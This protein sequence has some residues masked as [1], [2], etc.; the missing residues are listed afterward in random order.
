M[1]K[2][3]KIL[4]AAAALIGL[5]VALAV[6]AVV[7]IDPTKLVNDKKEALFATVSTKLGRTL[8]TGTV[9]ASLGTALTATIPDVRLTAATPN[10]PPQLEIRQIY[11]R[12]SLLRALF[13]LGR[14]LR[15][16]QITVDGLVLRAARDADGRFDFQDMLDKF[17]AEDTQQKPEEQGANAWSGLRIAATNVREARMELVDHALGRPLAVSALHIGTSDIVP[18]DPLSLWLTAQLEDGQRKSPVDVRAR[19]AQLPKDFAFD[20]LPD[21]DVQVKVT[22][23][24][25]GPWGALLPGE[26]A[27]PVQGVVRTDLS[28]RLGRGGES[29]EVKGT[30]LVRGLVLREATSAAATPAERL[31][32]PRGSSIDADVA[33]D[34]KKDGDQLSVQ[35]FTLTG[36][37]ADVKAS[38]ELKGSGL[39]GLQK[40][41]VT[42]KVQNMATLLLALPPSLRGLPDAVRIDGPLDAHLT[43]DG[44]ALDGA[45]VLDGARVRYLSKDEETGEE[46]IAFD[47]PPQKPFHLT[48]KGKRSNKA[49]DVDTFALV[50]DTAQLSGTLSFPLQDDAPMTADIHSGAVQLS[51]LQGLV[52]PFF[53]ALKKGQRVEGTVEVDVKAT[54]A[55]DKQQADAAIVLKNLDVNLG[56]TLARGN[57]SITLKAAPEGDIVTLVGGADLDQLSV[58]KIGASGQATLDKPAGLPLRLDIDAKKK[59]R[60]ADIHSARLVVGKSTL[61][62]KGA[63]E[64]VGGNAEQLDLD[65]GSV[66][67]AFNDLRQAVPG[68]SSL[69]A[70]GRLRGAL[71]LQGKLSAAGLGVDAKKVDVTFGSSHI[72][73]DVVIK[74]FDDPILNINLP[75]IALAFDDLRTLR[76]SLADLPRGGRYEGSVVLTGDTKRSSSV[77]L[78]AKVDKLIAARSDLKG[79]ISIKNLD[80]PRFELTSDSANLDVDALRDAFLGPQDSSS[81]KKAKDDNPHG[82]SKETRALLSDVN[83]K[84]TLKAKRAI[85][86]GMVMSDFVGDLTMTNG[87][88]TFKTLEFGFYGGRV[89]A[90]G[91]TLHLP[92][93]RLRY[94]IK[95]A[96]KDIDFGAALAS[97]TPL[98]RLFR[99]TTSPK[100]EVKGKGIAPGDF[101]LSAEGP[102]ELAFKSLT[103]ASFDLLTPLSDAMQKT[104]KAPGFNAQ[105]AKADVGSGISLQN[106]T[107]LTRFF[108]G[109]LKLDKPFEAD[110]PLGKMKMEGSAGLDAALDL[111]ATLQLTPQMIS[112]MTGGK[113]KVKDPVPVPMRIGGSWDAPKVSGIDVGALAIAVAG[114]QIE[115]AINNKDNQKRAT[116]AAKDAL[117]SVLGGNKRKKK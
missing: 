19:L 84:G 56:T 30:V 52:P 35:N 44:N 2:T 112:K 89:Q 48:L 60:R 92:S 10:G 8:T 45:V 39:A 83:G 61:T 100:L 46:S 78:S 62:G 103:I 97:Q 59:G 42:A 36:S 74:N 67:V 22:D 66:D 70:G 16:E 75:T 17:A 79:H 105:A 73:G 28:T 110:T 117:G 20:P 5:V 40:A 47:K 64:D 57:G 87:M 114:Q 69:P 15:V 50:I 9:T 86:N 7:V 102:A 71:R 4:V 91:T 58:K 29:L 85:V 27:A 95:F 65:F 55:G 115:D 113:V 23:L 1:A 31:S 21:L 72:A 51:S 96:G 43:A 107:A 41:H 76:P 104:N 32:A 25:V 101:A 53:D 49:L 6:V 63:V 98:A 14:D 81:P 111:R 108:G 106:F 99:G 37:G 88:V 80:A 33:I 54:A 38:A 12:F 109:K 34:M 26:S 3:K 11:A 93:E 82:L 77:E 116:D 13:T 90:S 18:G 24:D 68:A 94:D